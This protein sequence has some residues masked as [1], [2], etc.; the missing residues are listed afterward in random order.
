MG[1]DLDA[2]ENVPRRHGRAGFVQDLRHHAGGGG[3]QFLAGLVGLQND[4]V[5]IEPHLV[6]DLDHPLRD[7]RLGD[8]LACGGCDDVDHV[9][10]V[11]IGVRD[12]LY[13][14][15]ALGARRRRGS[16][17]LNYGRARAFVLVA[18]RSLRG[19]GAIARS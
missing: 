1:A 3:G 4:E 5:L 8:G 12:A 11:T 10:L 18:A 15:I 19:R 17:G 7:I 6:A 16:G 13:R 14:R 2:A 9:G